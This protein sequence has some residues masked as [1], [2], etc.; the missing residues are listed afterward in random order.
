MKK[1]SFLSSLFVAAT[2][3]VSAQE[4]ATITLN[5]DKAEQI[6]PKE[7]YGQF[8]EHL[9]SCIYGGLWVGEDSSI[10]NPLDNI[11]SKATRSSSVSDFVLITTLLL[12][13][14]GAT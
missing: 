3:T 4:S 9:G 1:A 11:S 10:P 12:F 5:T 6:I 13:L 7:I 14:T 2:L 8:A